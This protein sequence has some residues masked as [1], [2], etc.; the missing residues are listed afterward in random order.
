MSNADLNCGAHLPVDFSKL[1]RSIQT[2]IVQDHGGNLNTV[3]YV[4]T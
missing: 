3:G 2:H 4:I 1:T